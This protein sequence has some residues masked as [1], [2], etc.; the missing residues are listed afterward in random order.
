MLPNRHVQAGFPPCV[1]LHIV[2]NAHASLYLTIDEWESDQL[3]RGHSWFDWVSPEERLNAIAT[4]SVWTCQWYPDTPIGFNA[5]AASTF[6][7]LM[8]AVNGCA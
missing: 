5:L 2:F 8:E 6:E 4:D 7:A 1:N 3:E